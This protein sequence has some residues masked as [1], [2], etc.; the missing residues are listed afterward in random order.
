MDLLMTEWRSLQSD[1]STAGYVA[2]DDL[3][4]ALHL[5]LMLERPLLLEGAAGVGKTRSRGRWRGCA[6]RG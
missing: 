4:M 2:A 5:S 3:A 1:L 6:A